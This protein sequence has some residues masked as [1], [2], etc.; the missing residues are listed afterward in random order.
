LTSAVFEKGL[1]DSS[2][3]KAI[4]VKVKLYLVTTR[5]LTNA[6]KVAEKL[7]G[8]NTATFTCEL[9]HHDKCVE[10]LWPKTIVD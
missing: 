3:G 9:W 5:P 10:E 1:Q 7:A 2:G 6:A 8:L 4:A